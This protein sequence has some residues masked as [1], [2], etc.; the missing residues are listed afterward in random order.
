MGCFWRFQI[1]N[2]LFSFRLRT[3]LILV[4]SW[5]S[6]LALAY[7]ETHPKTVKALILSEKPSNFSKNEVHVFVFF[8]FFLL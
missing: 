3:Q 4:G 6:T 7:A 8:L 5:G 1:E 2:F